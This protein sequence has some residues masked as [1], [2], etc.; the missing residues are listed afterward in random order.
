MSSSTRRHLPSRPPAGIT[1]IELII[2]VAVLAI[3]VAVATPSFNEISLR[4]R[5]TSAINNLMAD[6]A[7]ARNEAVKTARD[8]YVSR[9]GQWSEGWDVWVD[10]NLN[11]TRDAD[12]PILRAQPPID[13]DTAAAAN[14]FELNAVAGATA[15]GTDI[16]EISFGSLGQVRTPADGARFALCRPDGDPAKSTGVRVDV[17]GRAQSVRD[18]AGL[19]LGCS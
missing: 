8:A 10:A 12:E 18:L 14:S 19:T 13:S 1:L 4:N 7:L 15:G 9:R 5:S 3:L 2:A 17:S 6:L 16:T 11:G